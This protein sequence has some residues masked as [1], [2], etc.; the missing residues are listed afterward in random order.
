MVYW[1]GGPMGPEGAVNMRTAAVIVLHAFCRGGGRDV[2]PGDVITDMPELEAQVKEERGWVR[3]LLPGE[4][5]ETASKSETGGS[6]PPGKMKGK[7]GN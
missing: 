6:E 3:R 7:P 5:P 1:K 2:A 4:V